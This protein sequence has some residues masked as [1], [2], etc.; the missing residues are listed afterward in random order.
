MKIARKFLLIVILVIVY[1][2]IFS[3]YSKAILGFGID[4]K[5]DDLNEYFTADGVVKE[6]ELNNLSLEELQD[7]Y[8]K[9]V[10][11]AGYYEKQQGEAFEPFKQKYENIRDIIQ[12]IMVNKN[13]D[14][15]NNEIDEEELMNITS[16]DDLYSW[17]YNNNPDNLSLDVKNHFNSIIDEATNSEDIQI[18]RK[19]VFCLQRMQGNDIDTSRE[20]EENASLVGGNR[21]LEIYKGP[22]SID[23]GS[24]GSTID[25]AIKQAENFEASGTG[26]VYN[27]DDLQSFSKNMYNILLTLGVGTAVI[28]GM[29]LGIRFVMV[30]VDEKADI[31]KQLVV[32]VAGCIIVF[33]AFAIW[34]LV[35]GLFSN[36]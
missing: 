35:V 22:N 11:V 31:K 20:A 4:G 16:I 29:I 36:I 9:A 17:L 23:L 6:D 32:Y 2:L 18:Y 12:Q 33:G 27:Q 15:D 21:N 1:L 26:N 10:E 14:S 28:V 30:G 8:D 5:E 34:K 3:T 25:D 19:A 24:T 13:G 7:L